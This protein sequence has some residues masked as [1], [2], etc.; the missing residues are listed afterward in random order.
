MDDAALT[1]RVFYLELFLDFTLASLG[2][3]LPRQC[4]IFQLLTVCVG[5]RSSQ[6]SALGSVFQVLF[7]LFHVEVPIRPSAQRTWA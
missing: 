4:H 6:Y 5:G 2:K 1:A 3:L 7:N